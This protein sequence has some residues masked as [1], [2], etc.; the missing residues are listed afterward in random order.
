MHAVA[1]VAQ[2]AIALSVFF[3]WMFR[4]DNIVRDFKTFG[5]SDVFRNAVGVVKLVSA[6]LLLV[7]IWMA[8][9]ALG[10]SLA[11]AALMLGAQWA[12]ASV[13]NPMAKRLPSALLLVLSVFVAVESAGL[14][15]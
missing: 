9:V 5:Y 1:V 12:H 7:G 10:A 11:M 2:V 14:L 6:T 15:R 13:A 8:P 4:F 3:V